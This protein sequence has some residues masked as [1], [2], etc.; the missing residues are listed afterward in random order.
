MGQQS[1]SRLNQAPKKILTAFEIESLIQEALKSFRAMAPVADPRTQPIYGDGVMDSMA[2]VIFLAELEARIA[3]VS[4]Y[5]L[6]LAN[7]KAMS[8]S[9]SP[10]RNVGVLAD[11]VGEI[12]EAASV[13]P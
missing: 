4:G 11:F 12:M 10:Y 6:V 2:L 7:E 8:R 13:R 5:E 9:Q 3:D 1:S